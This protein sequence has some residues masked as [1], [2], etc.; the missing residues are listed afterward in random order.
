VTQKVTYRQSVLL[1]VLVG[2]ENK[3]YLYSVDPLQYEDLTHHSINII[4]YN[5]NMAYMV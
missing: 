5:T 2:K 1:L 4:K 3:I